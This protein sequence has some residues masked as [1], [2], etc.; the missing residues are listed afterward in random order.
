MG[1]ALLFDGQPFDRGT[2]ARA[3]MSRWQLHRLVAAGRV[4]RV[5]D[6]VYLD[7]RVDDDL[8][9]R[10]RCL[11]LRLPPGAALSRWTAAWLLGVDVRP[12]ASRREPLSVVECTVPRGREPLSR[13][14]LVCY[15]APLE[16][17]VTEVAGLPCTTPERTVADLL[18]WSAPHDGLAAADAMAAAGLV[19]AQRLPAVVE[20]F[21][22][23]RGVT[24]ARYLAAVVEPATE[25]P[26]ESWL[27]LRLL[28]AGFP[29]PRAQ[30]SVVDRW[31]VERYRLDLGWEEVRVA[32]EYDG[33]EFHGSARSRRWDEQRREELFREFG[34][35]VV[36]VGK[37]EV[38]GPS[39][40]LERGVG[41]MLS[42]EPK[43]SRR[44][45]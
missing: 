4:R 5:L 21:A 10:A 13:R 24:Q 37:G 22:G 43:L 40:A 8:S 19:E 45:W 39:M 36:G 27:R 28:D 42:L 16:L 17:D 29:R 14:G 41:E 25:S 18:R 12:L 6:D 9:A 23:A 34:W 44:R 3:G 26:G 11:A 38:L 1:E 15:V 31:G 2:A 32:V 30:I 35:N 20:R 33:E 7:D